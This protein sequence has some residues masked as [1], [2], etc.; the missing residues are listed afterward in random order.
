MG[1][2]F[3]SYDNLS[4]DYIPDNSSSI[5]D[6]QLL[7]LSTE[8]PRKVYDIKNRFIGYACTAGDTFVLSITVN[9]TISIDEDSI[10]YTQKG[11]YPTETTTAS[12]IGQRAYNIVDCK[13]WVYFGKINSLYVWAED[14]S[15]TYPSDGNVKITLNRDM[16]NKNLQLDIFNFRWEHIHSFVV[17]NTPDIDLVLDKELS[18]KL[19]ASVYYCVIKITDED[20]SQTI[21]KFMLIVN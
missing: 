16:S 8:V 13:S 10:I 21:D 12:H 2:M 1:S 11:E 6:K 15:L 5:H 14:D 18:D 20:S 19:P 4:S 9:T 17:N 3:E 7:Q